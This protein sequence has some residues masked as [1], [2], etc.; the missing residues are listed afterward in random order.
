MQ[1]N[2]LIQFPVSIGSYTSFV[3]KITDLARMQSSAYVCVANVHMLIEAYYDQEFRQVL[4]GAN[5]VAP[6]GMPITWGLSFFHGIKQDRVAG[7]D[8]LPDLLQEMM[9]K[10]LSVCFYG[11]SQDL[12]NITRLYVK[13]KFPLLN[14][15]GYHS[16]PYRVLTDVEIEATINNINLSKANIVFVVLGCPKQEKWMAAMKGK[17]NACMVGIGGALPVMVGLQKRAPMWMQ[18]RGL[19]WLYR[20]YSEPRRMFK[21]YAITNSVFIFLVF[22]EFIKVKFLKKNNAK[23]NP[24]DS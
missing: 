11:G 19:E 7:M 8:L 4:K 13:E 16:P 17:I 21:R 10:N 6:D 20:L 9:Q 1:Q 3:D 12:L 24:L 15:K 23:K 14:V 2:T 22:K 18:V 5:I